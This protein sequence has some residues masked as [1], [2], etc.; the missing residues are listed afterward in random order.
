MYLF[1]SAVFSIRTFSLHSSKGN[2]SLLSLFNGSNSSVLERVGEGSHQI[3]PC[4]KNTGFPV[5]FSAA[6]VFTAAMVSEQTDF[7]GGDQLSSSRSHL[8]T[9]KPK[10]SELHVLISHGLHSLC[11][12]TAKQYYRLLQVFVRDLLWMQT[13][14]NIFFWSREVLIFFSIYS[15]WCARLCTLTVLKDL[16]MTTFWRTLHRKCLKSLPSQ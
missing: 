8:P 15:F 10:Q 4:D 9:I 14:K 1:L 13:K 6:V 2:K 11:C 3:W 12:S 7:C 16:R 5:C